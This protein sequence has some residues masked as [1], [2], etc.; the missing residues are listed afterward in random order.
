MYY[1]PIF[2]YLHGFS[3]DFTKNC[4]R[5]NSHDIHTVSKDYKTFV[6]LFSYKNSMKSTVLQ[7]NGDESNDSLYRDEVDFTE[8]LFTHQIGSF[9]T[10]L[11]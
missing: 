10:F 4:V 5:E 2:S 9:L 6:S 8:F 7:M 3:I 11:G 1:V